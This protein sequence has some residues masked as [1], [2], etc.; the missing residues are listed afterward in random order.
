MDIFNFQF[1]E[2]RISIV[3]D[4][5]M[6]QPGFKSAYLEALETIKSAAEVGKIRE[7]EKLVELV[8]ERLSKIP[9]SH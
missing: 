2:M 4:I 9:D 6:E 1:L 7:W 8:D 3:E 5:L